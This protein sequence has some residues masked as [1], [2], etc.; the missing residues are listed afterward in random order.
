MKAGYI[1][2]DQRKKILL[3]TDDIRVHSGVGQI[4]RELIVNTAHHYNWVQLAGSIQ[5]PEKGKLI[6]LSENLNQ[7]FNIPD[8]SFMLY[9]CDGYGDVRLLRSVIQ[10]EK[11]DAI[12]LITDPRYFMWL[13]QIENEIRKNIPILY[14]NI[15]DS[16]F[17]YPLWNK[18]FYKSCD[19]LMAISKQTKNINQVVLGEVPKLDLDKELSKNQ[20]RKPN[21]RSNKVNISFLP[22]GL[23]EKIFYPI[24]EPNPGF[25]AFKKSIFKDKEFDFVLFFNSRNIRRKQ[26][27]DTILAWRL[28]LDK[29][30]PK[31]A[32]KC[33]FILH[34]EAVSEHGTDIPATIDYLVPDY[35]HNVMLSLNKLDSQH[36]NYLYNVADAQIL[37]TSNEGWGLSLTE[38][39][40]TG[41]PF[42][43]NVQGGMQ[44]QMRFEDENGKWL[45][46]NIDFPS[47]HRGTYKKHGEWASPVFPSNI[48]IQ[49]SPVTPYISDDRCSPEDA[50]ERIFE[51]FSLSKEERERRGMLGREWAVGDEA[52]F[53]SEKMG[54]K[55][56]KDVD[57]TLE[58][59]IPRETFSL[60]NCTEETLTKSINH[61]LIY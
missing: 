42:I 47:N 24:V 32:E 39:L 23:N 48:S 19:L 54:N 5:H 11:P 60:T 35:G 41:T 25:D 30:T 44:D 34:T 53:T 55:F 14:L 2:K 43:A 61:Q 29:L 37:L 16:P 22:H 40:L 49:G 6:D 52:N 17:P 33:A 15:W 4:G 13:F 12:F 9:P 38:A 27:P 8:S 3:L 57:Y 10:R 59:F 51:M 36:M 18:S 45:D 20:T 56:I 21:T 31:Q 7:E 28:F 1:P 26:I 46:F 58:N 50:A